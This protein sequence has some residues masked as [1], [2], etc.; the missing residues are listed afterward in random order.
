MRRFTTLSLLSA[1]LVALVGVSCVVPATAQAAPAA[2][3][4][5]ISSPQAD[6]P[7]SATITR[8]DYTEADITFTGH[9]GWKVSTSLGAPISSS[10]RIAADGTVTVT[11][12]ITK[13]SVYRGFVA[14]TDPA[15]PSAEE[16]ADLFLDADLTSPTRPFIGDVT[17]G[18][19]P[20]TVSATSRARIGGFLELYDAAGRLRGSSLVPA[21]GA[22]GPSYAPENDVTV[23][24]PSLGDEKLT[25]RFRYGAFVSPTAPVTVG[26]LPAPAGTTPP[27]ATAASEGST[28]RLRIEGETGAVARVYDSLGGLVAQTT[29]GA[30][31]GSA[32]VPSS[33]VRREYR[34]TQT[35]SRGTSAAATVTIHPESDAV[36]L[37][38]PTVTT[39]IDLPT[40]VYTL[41][42]TAK[43][44]A[45]LRLQPDNSAQPTAIKVVGTSGHVQ[46]RVTQSRD[47]RYDL[48][49]QLDGAVSPATSV[50]L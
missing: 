23:T 40:S 8:V 27:T 31:G 34:V 46:I 44:G 24:A 16:S 12:P 9:P 30:G 22:T 36:T 17:P 49:Q 42:I 39:S 18:T 21:E 7:F 32:N 4:S 6:L 19:E 50:I 11:Y 33:T 38:A 43:P 20:G 15:D 48:T 29:L 10:D 25:A 1:G 14:E 35:T 45:V 47:S 28:T 41:D 13:Y 5:P 26:T 37:P 3:A 2:A